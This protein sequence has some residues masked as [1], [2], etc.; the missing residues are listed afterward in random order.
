MKIILAPMEGVVD[1]VMRDVL[2]RIGGIDL[3]VTEFVRIS[4]RLLPEHVYY[5]LAPELRN[6]GRT[7]AGVPVVVQLLGS[8]PALMAENAVRAAQL[9]AP[10][11]DLNFGC[12]AK[13]VNKNRGGAV[14]L[15]TP[16]DIHA[17]VAAVR[18]AVPSSVPVT[19]KMRLGNQDKAL[20]LDNARAI[21]DAGADG[22]AVHAR[23]KR[24]GYRPPAHWEWIARIREAVPE[25]PLTANGEVW[26][27]DD[28]C[29]CREASGCDDVMIGRGLVSRPD[30][31]RSISRRLAGEPEQALDWP[32]LQPVLRGYF[33]R[34]VREMA[35]G[36]VHGRLKQWL[37]QM[38]RHY[39]EAE[40]L[41]GEIKRLRDIDALRQA[42]AGAE[43]PAAA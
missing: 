9:G 10:G 12:P 20:A 29:R 13:T 1:P 35:P 8:D 4:D 40:T 7:E 36:Y 41:F 11:I 2:T 28:Y 15:D 14:L 26:S 31:A 19:A 32:Q 22:L 3:C 18:K 43:E 6:G 33:E 5:R 21:R 25:I 27:W 16:D 42:L 37:N 24:E 17:I 38:K 39:P 34:M 23:T 30:L